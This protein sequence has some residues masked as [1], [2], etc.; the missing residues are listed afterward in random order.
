MRSSFLAVHCEP[1]AETAGAHQ[2]ATF[3]LLATIIQAADAFGAKVTFA[4]SPQ[5]AEFISRRFASRK[6]VSSWVRDGHELAYHHHGF[7]NLGTPAGWDGYSSMPVAAGDVAYRG[8]AEDAYALV[9]SV[10]PG[11]P[12]TSAMMS[13]S[14]ADWVPSLS[15]RATGGSFVSMPSTDVLGPE[16]TSVDVL[17]YDSIAGG[18]AVAPLEVEAAIL[19]MGSD[20]V[21]GLVL[22]AEHLP[23]VHSNLLTILDTLQRAG[24][25]PSTLSSLL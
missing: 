15:R 7:T 10:L 2:T 1:A 22:H 23:D 14:N 18:D 8:T 20:D 24:M 12:V 13:D 17:T 21:L 19:T 4:L 11:V 3:P 6:L 5:W 25:A 16:S 9:S